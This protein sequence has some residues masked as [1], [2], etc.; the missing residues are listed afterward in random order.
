[1]FYMYNKYGLKNL[2]SLFIIILNISYVNAQVLFENIILEPVLVSKN[3]DKVESIN[4]FLMFKE[5]DSLNTHKK[6]LVFS[7]VG[8]NLIGTDGK[9]IGER[10]C[11]QYDGFNFNSEDFCNFYLCLLNNESTCLSYFFK[12]HN[13]FRYNVFV[14]V[15]IELASTKVSKQINKLYKKKNILYSGKVFILNKVL[16]I[17][18][19]EVHF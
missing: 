3:L 10:D 16:K 13:G 6:H 18:K 11:K 15:E 17:N 14:D 1:M 9:F 8:S 2:V 19:I 12:S 4:S 5:E 7:L